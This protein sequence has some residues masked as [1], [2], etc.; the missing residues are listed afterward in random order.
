[1]E[2]QSTVTTVPKPGAPPTGLSRTDY[3]GQDGRQR[4]PRIA[5][6]MVIT[7]IALAIIGGLF[8]YFDRSVRPVMIGQILKKM[9]P[10]PPPV[11]TA[12]AK[13]EDVPQLLP[14]VGTLQAVHQ[15]TVTPEVG[16]SVTKILFQSGAT[17]TAGTPLLQL[18]D[19]PQQGDLA[20]YKAQAKVAELDLARYRALVAK[21]A[22]SQQTVD[23]QAA[24]LDQANANIAKTNA[25]IAQLLV[26]APFDGVLGVRQVDVG[27][28]V[29]AGDA[30]V[31]LTDLDELYANF[32]L[33]EGERGRVAVGQAVR[34]TVDAF[35]GRVFEGTIT[36]IDPQIS[37]DTRTVKLQ[38]TIPNKD[39]ALQPGM[40]SNVTVVLPATPNQVTL[41]ETAVDYSLY[42][43]SVYV[44][45]PT[46]DKDGKPVNGEDGKPALHVDRV[47]VK[48]GDRA[49]GKVVVL[50]GVNP[51]DRVVAVGQNKLQNGAPVS[52]SEQGAPPA[53]AQTPRP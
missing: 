37:S 26:R 30:I 33:A 42:G 22:T 47:F 51:G 49:D 39:H 6:F 32:T 36:A 7:V 53:P 46:V 14:A 48:T 19:K 8:V 31:T 16:G 52:L 35:P 5:L 41:P 23:Q 40:F 17:V 25:L 43:N 18:N 3:R 11:A 44:V 10:P 34:V 21:Q 13:T 50:S 1:M 29:K 24:A 2:S 15:V 12:V 38:A 4:P 28:Y 45:R 27:Q 20:N 9:T